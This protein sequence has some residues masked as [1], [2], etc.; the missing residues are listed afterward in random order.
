MPVVEH[1]IAMLMCSSIQR[2]AFDCLMYVSV[3]L[4]HLSCA[5][6]QPLA[7][8]LMTFV[9]V[10]HGSQEHE[11][12]YM[13]VME[14][15]IEYIIQIL[16]DDLRETEPNELHYED[17]EK[18]GGSAVAHIL[19]WLI[20]KVDCLSTANITRDKVGSCLLSV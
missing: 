15:V 3:G 13:M 5:A 7:I 10:L 18:I 16:P 4:H 12:L 11:I 2:H 6:C 8:H 17:L 9:C 14:A 20:E 19:E 1:Y